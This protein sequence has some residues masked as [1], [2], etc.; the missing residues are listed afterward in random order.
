MK[1]VK[2]HGRKL[3]V[4]AGVVAAT[5]AGVAGTESGSKKPKC[6]GQERWMVKTLQDDD[7][8][9]IDFDSPKKISIAE[10]LQ[11]VKGDAWRKA[12]DNP[13]LEDEFEVFKVRGKIKYVAKENDGDIHIQ[14]ADENN[15]KLSIVA[16]IPNP[17]CEITKNSEYKDLFRDARNDFTNKY[18]DETVWSK[19]VFE[20]VGVMFH[21][22]SNHSKY[23]G[24]QEGVEIHPVISIKKIKK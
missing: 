1:A 2:K 16:E 22:I 17:G 23:G 4:A 6:I 11:K 13:R 21:D 24:N 8:G 18:Q 7:A 5:F 20:I 14:L 10:I 12:K 9:S 19:G 3:V 15:P